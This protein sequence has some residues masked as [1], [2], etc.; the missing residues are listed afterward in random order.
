MN[1][2]RRSRRNEKLRRILLRTVVW[3][4]LAVFILTSVGVALVNFAAR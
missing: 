2:Q 1:A 4:V 3:I